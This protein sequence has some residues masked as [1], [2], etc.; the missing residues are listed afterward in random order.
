MFHNILNLDI[1]YPWCVSRPDIYVNR[2]HIP[3]DVKSDKMHLFSKPLSI[4]ALSFSVNFL[5]NCIIRI[6]ISHAMFRVH[7]LWLSNVAVLF[8]H[9]AVVI[10]ASSTWFINIIFEEKW[11]QNG[12]LKM[13]HNYSYKIMFQFALNQ[14][15]KFPLKI[16][17]IVSSKFQF[18]ILFKYLVGYL[19]NVNIPVL[20]IIVTEENQTLQQM[21]MNMEDV[22]KWS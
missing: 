4:N 3:E 8:R 19:H 6:K 11:Q 9:V 20:L 1:Y 16:F 12:L 15:Y 22:W 2:L 10:A 18:A 7:F 17:C 5:W 14:N 21:I 13:T